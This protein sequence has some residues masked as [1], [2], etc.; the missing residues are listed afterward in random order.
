MTALTTL[1]FMK[2]QLLRSD[3]TSV[4]PVTP[5]SDYLK[6]ISDKSEDLLV[7]ASKVQNT[8]FS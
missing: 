8:R 7:K 2:A 4:G 6:M 1:L 5:V 3:V